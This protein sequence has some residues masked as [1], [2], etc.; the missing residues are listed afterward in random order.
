LPPK[1]PFFRDTFDR[2]S[3]TISLVDHHQVNQSAWQRLFR[4]AKADDGDARGQLLEKYRRYLALLARLQLS[5]RLP[6]KV[7]RLDVVQEVMLEAYCNLPQFR[8]VDE[9]TFVAWLRRILAQRV[10]SLVQHYQ[11]TKRGDPRLGIAAAVDD[12]SRVL[13]GAQVLRHSASSGRAAD[14]KHAIRPAD[15]LAQLPDDQREV[16]VLRHLEDLPLPE[17]AARLDR[18]VDTIKGLWT[19]GLHRLR[20]I[21]GSSP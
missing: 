18:S 17:V 3:V 6:G 15:A 19:L 10:A 1:K 11:G 7:H 21:V 2:L 4:R 13:D 8:G 5:R 20:Q 9:P 16:L 14:S 12:L